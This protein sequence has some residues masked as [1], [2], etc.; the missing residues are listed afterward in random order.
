[1]TS[2]LL[3]DLGRALGRIPTGLFV[4]ATQAADGPIGFVASFLVQTGFEPPTLCLAIGRGRDHLAAI[5]SRGRF[6]V[7]ILDES[8]RD[9]IAAFFRKYPPGQGPFDQLEVAEASNGSPV[10]E[11]ALAWLECRLIGEFDAGGDHIVVFGE[12][13]DASLQ[14]E[15]DP[16]VH[17]RKNGLSY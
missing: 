8:S 16:H 12:V 15:G 11:G 10:L 5:R 7:S 6:S 1:M 4:V 3:S 2:P 13:T 17:L 9:V 14:R